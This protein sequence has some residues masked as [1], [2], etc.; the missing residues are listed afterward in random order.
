MKKKLFSLLFAFSVLFVTT[1]SIESYAIG[2]S[3]QS[4]VLLCINNGKVLFSKNENVKLSMASTTKILTSLIAL[5]EATPDREIVVTDEMV[6]VEGTS[7]GLIAGDSVSLIDLVYGMMLQS[8]NDAANTVAYVIGNNP[9]EFAKI[10]NKRAT[11]I[12]MNNSNF[13]TASGLDDKNHYSTAYDMALLASECIKNPE[14]R[15]ICS[16]KSAR[17]TYGNPPYTRTLTNHNR[18][19]WRYSDCIGIKTGFT[20]KSGR[21]LVS[22]SERNGIILVAVTLNAGDDWND[23]ISMFEYG[24][25]VCKPLTIGCKTQNLTLRICGGTDNSIPLKLSRECIISEDQ[26][27]HYRLNIKPFEYAPVKKGELVGTA[28]FISENGVIDEVPVITDGSC[29]RAEYDIQNNDITEKKIS[30][31]EKIKEFV[32][33]AFVTAFRGERIGRQ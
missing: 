15:Y 27:C 18:L 4:A 2:V 29:E 19:L 30:L 3:A 17:L 24:F 31:I 16:R 12:G 9:E 28:V 8:G 7:M 26:I 22:A 5:E 25:S 6:S 33:N 21:C 1:F 10:M 11:E 23:H 14:F 13:V 20:K 32:S